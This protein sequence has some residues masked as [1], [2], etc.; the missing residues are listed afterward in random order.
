MRNLA[1]KFVPLPAPAGNVEC[2]WCRRMWLCKGLFVN[3]QWYS[4]LL[5][6]MCSAL[7]LPELKFSVYHWLK[8]FGIVRGF[9]EEMKLA[10]SHWCKRKQGLSFFY[11]FLFLFTTSIAKITIHKMSMSWNSCPWGPA[12][13]PNACHDRWRDNAIRC[14]ECK[15]LGPAKVISGRAS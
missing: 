9:N 4:L 1:L 7:R 3:W 13:A 2:H 12:G 15:H 10:D 8:E 14:S 11:L 5:H 6:T